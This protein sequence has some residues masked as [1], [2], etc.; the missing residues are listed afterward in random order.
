MEN[1]DSYTKIEVI[2]PDAWDFGHRLFS[3]NI[4]SLSVHQGAL[5]LFLSSKA[6]VL[7]LFWVIKIKEGL[8]LV[9]EKAQQEELLKLLEQYHF[10]ENIELKVGESVEASWAPST[11]INYK[12]GF[13]ELHFDQGFTG[14]WKN[15]L[16]VFNLNVKSKTNERDIDAW[17]KHRKE[18][19]IPSLAEDFDNAPLVF[20]AGLEELCDDGKG[21]YI[22]QE[23][24]ERVRSKKR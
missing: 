19:G 2:G 13:G 7:A 15:T 1:L 20:H 11:E 3:R 8:I 6:K 24:V 10:S 5:S 22:G 12:N 23:I 21:C 17:S 16:W 9:C 14:F 4:N 18:N